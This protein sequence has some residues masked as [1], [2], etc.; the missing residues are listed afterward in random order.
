MK[1]VAIISISNPAFLQRILQSFV[2]LNKY[3]D[4][5][6]FVMDRCGGGYVI[7]DVLDKYAIPYEIVSTNF[8][9]N[10][11]AAGRPRD[12]GIK[13]L[14]AHNIKYQHIVFLDGDCL[15][16]P[17]LFAEHQRIHDHIRFVKYPCLVNSMRINIQEDGSQVPDVRINNPCVFSSGKDIVTVFDKHL[18]VDDAMY[19]AC[20]GCNVSLNA[21]AIRIAR[22]INTTILGVDRVFAH[23]FDGQWG[24]EDPYLSATLFRAGALC[25]NADPDKSH[26]RHCYHTSAHR[27]N[28]HV[29]HLVNALS[30]FNSYSKQGKLALPHTQ[31]TCGNFIDINKVLN[32]AIDI[33]APEITRLAARVLEKHHASKDDGWLATFVASRVYGFK[34]IN[35]QEQR[36]SV[37]NYNVFMNTVLNCCFEL[38]QFALT[39][40][41]EGIWN[42]SNTPR[43]HNC[44]GMFR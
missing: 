26:V 20:V 13:Y 9:D 16:S 33:K 34:H 31:I 44:H 15:P 25:V 12:L 21:E 30:R 8:A 19:P 38:H 23:V 43:Q 32:T 22:K 4:L 5:T 1:Q 14:E 39:E 2:C 41:Y 11:F 42:G 37:S 36:R 18:Y 24:G 10:V 27:N 29:R 6:L 28:N 40:D 3:P 17:D 7:E 35:E